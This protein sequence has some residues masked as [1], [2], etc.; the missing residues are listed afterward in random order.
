MKTHSHGATLPPL[1]FTDHAVEV[2]ETA[3][4]A[5]LLAGG[6][7]IPSYHAQAWEKTIPGEPA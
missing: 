4:V 3:Y 6:A 5:W 2:I 1:D 7:T